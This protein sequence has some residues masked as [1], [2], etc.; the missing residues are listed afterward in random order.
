[1]I[2][3][4]TWERYPTLHEAREAAESLAHDE[5]VEHILIVRDEVPPSGVEW[6][7]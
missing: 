3:R 4:E 5:R 2:V 1:M 7:R 6:A